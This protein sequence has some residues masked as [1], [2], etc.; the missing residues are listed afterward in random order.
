M[1][2]IIYL[3]TRLDL[4]SLAWARLMLSHF[5]DAVLPGTTTDFEQYSLEISF[6]FFFSFFFFKILLL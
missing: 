2:I 1:S 4:A 5:R 3:V 6:F